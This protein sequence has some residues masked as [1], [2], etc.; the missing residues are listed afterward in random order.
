[1]PPQDPGDFSVFYLFTPEYQDKVHTLFC[2]T[3]SLHGGLGEAFWKVFT[4]RT[5]QRYFLQE[6]RSFLQEQGFKHSPKLVESML[7]SAVELVKVT[8]GNWAASFWLCN[9][10]PKHSDT[11]P[12]FQSSLSRNTSHGAVL[13]AECLNQ[14]FFFFFFSVLDSKSNLPSRAFSSHIHV[15]FPARLVH[16]N[17]GWVVTSWL[18]QQFTPIPLAV[19][20]LACSVHSSG[21]LVATREFANQSDEL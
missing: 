4:R 16:S 7:K 2:K 3:S 9:P 14:V 13:R 21:S 17:L 12:L 6:E 18:R 10:F 19:G 8:G 1:M 5:E 20:P 15:T 11:T